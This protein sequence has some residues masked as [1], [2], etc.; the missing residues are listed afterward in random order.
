MRKN[1]ENR[2]I[3]KPA[4]PKKNGENASNRERNR[5]EAGDYDHDH[6]AVYIRNKET[7][8]WEVRNPAGSI[9]YNYLYRDE[10]EAGSS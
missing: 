2:K 6:S 7:G 3:Q 9:G 10:P 1:E 5:Q 4:K 8:Q